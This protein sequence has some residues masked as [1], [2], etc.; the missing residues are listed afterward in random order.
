MG[1]PCVKLLVEAQ[2]S[3]RDQRYL[4]ADGIAPHYRALASLPANL[5]MNRFL[6]HRRTTRRGEAFQADVISYADD[7]IIL[8]RGHAAE[9]MAKTK[10]VMTKLGLTLDETKTSLKDTRRER[11]DFLG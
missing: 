2:N 5:C 8:S 10:G 6:K 9:A 1:P 7:F 11:F 4:A 3:T